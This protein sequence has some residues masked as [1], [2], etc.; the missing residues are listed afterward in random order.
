MFGDENTCILEI[1]K[2]KIQRELECKNHKCPTFTKYVQEPN[3][4]YVCPEEFIS[5]YEPVTNVQHGGQMYCYGWGDQTPH[6]SPSPSPSPSP[7]QSPSS[8]DIDE[9]NNIV[10]ESWKKSACEYYNASDSSQEAYNYIRNQLDKYI[11]EYD[12]K[13]NKNTKGCNVYNDNNDEYMNDEYCI[14]NKEGHQACRGNT[15]TDD[16]VCKT[17]LYESL[18]MKNDDCEWKHRN[19]V[20]DIEVFGPQIGAC[21]R[22]ATPL[23]PI[24]KTECVSNADYTICNQSIPEN[25]SVFDIYGNNKR[26]F[27]DMC[28]YI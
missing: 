19:F 3:G 14:Q 2:D 4:S 6:S 24:G 15:L 12:I 22:E 23:G 27:D 11:G 7:S 1:N 10:R 25:I 9:C 17:Y 5:I 13:F 18:C 16:N 20:D 21:P 26:D 28:K 8:T